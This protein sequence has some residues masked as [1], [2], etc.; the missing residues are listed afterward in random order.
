MLSSPRFWVCILLILGGV[1][2]YFY[3]VPEPVGHQNAHLI[4]VG[5][6]AATVGGCLGLCLAIQSF[7]KRKSD[8][9]RKPPISRSR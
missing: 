6:M 2:G 5:F 3:L 8:A 7:V 4:A 1:F 9:I